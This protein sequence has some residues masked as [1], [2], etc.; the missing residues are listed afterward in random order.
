MEIGTCVRG[1]MS[2]RVYKRWFSAMRVIYETRGAASFSAYDNH[3]SDTRRLISL[4]KRVRGRETR[5]CER[6][7]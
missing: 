3:R 7:R 6:E 1:L 4:D 5:V 2:P